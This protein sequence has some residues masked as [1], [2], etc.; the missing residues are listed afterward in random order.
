MYN[1][2][3]MQNYTNSYGQQ[4]LNERIDS[5][6]AQ[7]QQMKEQIKNNNQPAINQ[8]FQL[9]PNHSGIKYVNSLE[10]VKRENV[11]TDTPF[12]SKDLSVVWLKNAN[13]NI[14]AYELTEI[15]EKDS[16]DIQIEFL[17]AQIEELRGKIENDTN[18]TNAYAEQN[19]T[20]TTANDGSTGETI[21]KSKPSSI[22]KI[23]RSKTE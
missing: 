13:G 18:V 3:Y 12:F 21:K 1:N 9:A 4:N 22:Q 11:F 16:K 2:P 15:V 17:Q 23:S 14:K 10:E 20:N 8:T 6:I 7:L 19:E 5:Q